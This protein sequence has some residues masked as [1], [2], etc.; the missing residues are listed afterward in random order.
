MDGNRFEKSLQQQRGEGMKVCEAQGREVRWEENEMLQEG[1]EETGQQPVQLAALAPEH[2]ALEV[3]L[4]PGTPGR[5]EPEMC[6]SGRF[7]SIWNGHNLRRSVM[8]R[9]G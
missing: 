1:D 8:E 7:R 5:C 4:G 3:K 6:A 2:L 9:L